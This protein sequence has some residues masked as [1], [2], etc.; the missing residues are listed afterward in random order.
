[1]SADEWY[2]AAWMDTPLLGPFL[3]RLRASRRMNEWAHEWSEQIQARTE[4]DGKPVLKPGPRIENAPEKPGRFLVGVHSD[5][6]GRPG[7]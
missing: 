3:Q 5:G 7:D 4:H 1:M 2:A 6:G